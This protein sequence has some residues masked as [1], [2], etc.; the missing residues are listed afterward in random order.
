MGVGYWGKK[1]ED[2]IV[3]EFGR[4]VPTSPRVAA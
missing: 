2:K 1:K 3:L 4:R